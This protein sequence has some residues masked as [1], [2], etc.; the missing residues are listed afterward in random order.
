LQFVRYPSTNPI[1]VPVEMEGSTILHRLVNDDRH[2]QALD[3]AL[4]R[5]GANPDKPR[6][7]GYTPLHVAVAAGS[8]LAV[9]ALLQSGA[10]K[11][12]VAIVNPK[13]P[14]LTPYRFAKK[15]R[16][17]GHQPS[18]GLATIRHLKHFAAKPTSASSQNVNSE[19]S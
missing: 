17:H 19:P 10:R 3:Y 5:I 15:K 2:A 7:D 1:E 11:T 13:K 4:H 18:V 8:C 6:A 12:C 14:P 16:S 9:A